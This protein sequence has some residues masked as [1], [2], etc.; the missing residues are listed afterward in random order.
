[1][2]RAFIILENPPVYT[3]HTLADIISFVSII[4]DGEFLE[5]ENRI[6]VLFHFIVLC[7]D[8]RFIRI[9]KSIFSDLINL[10][11]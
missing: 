11:T 3:A 8:E 1:M 6:V 4:L 9:I 7:S 5:Y 10:V 2:H